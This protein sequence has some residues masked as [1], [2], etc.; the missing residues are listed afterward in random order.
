MKKIEVLD[1][2]AKWCGPC[3]S[4]TPII[5]DLISEYNIDGSD[6]EIKKIDVD[7]DSVL[8]HK[9]EI[10]SIPTFVFI[11]DGVEFDR[12]RGAISKEALVKKIELARTA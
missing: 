10:K 9:F 7:E 6:V 1:F 2:T 11:S 12:V 3:R 4:M 8:P 5:N